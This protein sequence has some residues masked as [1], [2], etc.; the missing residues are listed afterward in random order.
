[1]LRRVPL[2]HSVLITLACL[3][4]ICTP[5]GS[6]ARPLPVSIETPLD[7]DG[8]SALGKLTPSD[9]LVG[10]DV[11]LQTMLARIADLQSKG[12]IRSD[13]DLAHVKARAWTTAS[14]ILLSL[15]PFL[16]EAVFKGH[17]DIDS[18][19]FVTTITG[20]NGKPESAFG[21]AITRA[22][23]DKVDWSSASQQDLPNVTDHFTLG[24]VT[25]GHMKAESK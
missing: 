25:A 10:S 12:A 3:G 24:R 18:C 1:M 2:R 13:V 7:A 8:V 16:M 5:I 6:Q 15:Q 22:M 4:T 14:S 17:S 9:C 19:G 23:H 20:A 11:D 21:F